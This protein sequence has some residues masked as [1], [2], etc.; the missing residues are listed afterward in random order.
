MNNNRLKLFFS[1]F[2]LTTC[3]CY[4]FS[5]CTSLEEE[6]DYNGI[7]P[8]YHEADAPEE[9]KENENSIDSIIVAH[10]NIGHFSQGKSYNTSITAQDTDSIK[11]LYLDMIQRVNPDIF[12]IC[13]YNPIFNID[14]A[15]TAQLLFSSFP[16]SYI[17]K[18]YNYNCNSFFSHLP[19]YN[20]SQYF[21]PKCIQTRYYSVADIVLKGNTVKFVETHLDFNQNSDGQT[22]RSSQMEE[23]VNAFKDY[24]YVI[25]CADFNSSVR[26]E[27]D[28]FL[29]AGFS[30]ASDSLPNFGSPYSDI[31]RIKID[32]I[33]VKGFEVIETKEYPHNSLSDHNLYYCKLK[34]KE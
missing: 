1:C 30:L 13:E 3:T 8:Y 23:L 6:E 21:F 12:G 24:P 22:C 33:I 14:G 9:E 10:W 2:L 26:E 5:A 34:I 16:Y 29:D 4:V 28:I 19:L 15:N 32:N 31:S 20:C 7:N 25:I 17:G 27:Y 11:G 18:K